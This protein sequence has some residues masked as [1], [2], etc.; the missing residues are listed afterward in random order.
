MAR[1]ADVID[2][3]DL[4]ALRR[5]AEEVR[6][7]QRPCLLRI[8]DEGVTIVRPLAEELERRGRPTAQDEATSGASFGAWRGIVDGEQL[9]RDSAEARGSDRPGVEP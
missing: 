7:T 8:G 6:V 3:G 1:T 9:K 2:I 5:I 4:P